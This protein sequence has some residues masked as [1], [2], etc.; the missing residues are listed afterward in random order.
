MLLKNAASQIAFTKIASNTYAAIIVGHVEMDS[1]ENTTFRHSARQWR[2]S[3]AHCSLR[4]WWSLDNGS[5]RNGMR[6]TSSALK[7]RRRTVDA[8]RS[9]PVAVLQ[10]RL[11]TVDEAV[12]S[13]IAKMAVIPC[14]GH[15]TWSST[16]S[17]LRTSLFS[18]L[19]PYIYNS[20]SSMPYTSRNV[21][22]WQTCFP[23]TNHSAPFECNHVLIL[24]PFTSTRHTCTSFHVSTLFGSSVLAEQGL[25]LILL[26]TRE[27]SLLGLC[28]RHLSRNVIN[29][30]QVC[31]GFFYTFSY[32]FLCPKTEK[33]IYNIASHQVFFTIV[34]FIFLFWVKFWFS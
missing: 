22:V 17:S 30:T 9:K 4:R 31:M 5:R 23:E 29:Y 34:I 21:T 3:R 7:R 8:D 20:H 28:V 1:S 24:H 32:R 15:I 18:P 16:C 11:D 33:N 26:V 14:C 27:P 6:A 12:R 25:T 19:V 2:R 13:A 10:R